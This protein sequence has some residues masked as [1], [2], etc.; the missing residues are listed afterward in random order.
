[1]MTWQLALR[2]KLNSRQN[3]FHLLGYGCTDP[4]LAKSKKIL[5]NFDLLPFFKFFNPCF[6]SNIFCFWTKLTTTKTNLRI[7]YMSEAAMEVF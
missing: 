1:M 4:I 3:Q 2:N 7:Y 6:Y 5:Q